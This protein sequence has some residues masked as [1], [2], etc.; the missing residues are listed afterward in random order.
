MAEAP[1]IARAARI[2]QL[3]GDRTQPAVA[4]DAGVTLRAYQG[5]EAGHGIG[6][7]N[8]AKLAQA[9]RTSVTYLM[10]G[11]E[12][13]TR[14]EGEPDDVAVRL[15]R[16]REILRRVAAQE[17]LTAEQLEYLERALDE[18]E[19]PRRVDEAASSSEDAQAAA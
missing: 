10:D 15:N 14:V 12:V 9:L 2:R 17:L 19:H 13:P 6:K 16:Q 3:R 7:S 8:R 18:L 1:D 11:V 5:W 4:E